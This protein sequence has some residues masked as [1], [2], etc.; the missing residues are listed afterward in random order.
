MSHLILQKP[1]NKLNT[2]GTL[3]GLWYP[4]ARPLKIWRKTLGSTLELNGTIWLYNGTIIFVDNNSF[5]F[6]NTVVSLNRNP[7]SFMFNNVTY[8]LV[9]SSPDL[10][11][12][13]THGTVVLAS[14]QSETPCDLAQPVIETPLKN[15]KKKCDPCSPGSIISFSGYAG[16]KP[17][18]TNISNG[19]FPNN[20][21]YLRNRGNTFDTTSTLHKISGV[22]YASGSNPVWPVV[23]QSVEGQPV[24]S[25]S[26]A[27]N[28]VTCNPSKFAIYKPNNPGFS[29]QGAVDSST[30]L[31]KLKYAQRPELTQFQKKALK[32][33]LK[34]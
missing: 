16:I 19:Y 27:Y 25:S 23:A 34:K 18:S 5:V 6:H 13:S 1:T 29:T 2:S 11:F 31:W 20:Y 12:T 32:A 33:Q 9:A 28:D 15:I 10:V 21:Q 17:S 22:N 30:R 4:S 26:F 7:Y 14:L 8:T 24:T 3:S